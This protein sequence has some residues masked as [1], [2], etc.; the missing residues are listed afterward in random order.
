M[1]RRFR[2]SSSSPT[3]GRPTSS[4]AWSTPCSTA[5]R[6]SVPVID[7][8]HQIPPFDVAGGAAMLVA[9]RPLPRRRGGAGRGRPGGG[10]RPP[11]GGHPDR[12]RPPARLVG[13]WGLTD[14]A[15]G[16]R[17]VASWLVGPDNGL[18]AGRP[19]SSV[20]RRRSWPC[21]S[22][23]GDGADPTVGSMEPGPPSTAGTSSPRP[24]LTW[25][26][27]AI[28]RLLG[29]AVDPASLVAA[30]ADQMLRPMSAG[31]ERTTRVGSTVTRPRWSAD[32]PVR[33]RTAGAPAWQ[34]LD[35]MGLG[36][37]GWPR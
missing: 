9:L 18:L 35:E 27:G 10:D 20:A 11:G 1:S 16:A 21:R 4:W 37:V 6:R 13:P 24:P 8:S 3:T 36:P 17:T 2:P 28:R 32:R 31:P 30:A 5:W 14:R 29:A 7:L 15:G 19:R 12:R 25:S 22:M 34:L 26:T 33:Q 23:T